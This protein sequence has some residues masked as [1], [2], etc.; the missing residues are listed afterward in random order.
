MAQ[1]AGSRTI[2]ASASHVAMMSQ[3]RLTADL[4]ALAARATA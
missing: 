4:I 3:P 1:R 2:E